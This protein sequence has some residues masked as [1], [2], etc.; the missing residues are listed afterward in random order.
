MLVAM[1]MLSAAQAEMITVKTIELC[2]QEEGDQWV[3][4]GIVKNTDQSL[5]AIVIEHDAD[6]PEIVDLLVKRNVSSRQTR[7]DVEYSDRF[8]NLMLKVVPSRDPRASLTI[9]NS[10]EVSRPGVFKN[11]SWEGL[12]CYG[13]SEITYPKSR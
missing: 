13:P 12:H 5:E 1:G 3:E 6:D 7:F 8:G 4:I 11:R 10:P 2:Q 9:V